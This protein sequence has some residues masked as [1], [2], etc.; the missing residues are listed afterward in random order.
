MRAEN[1]A[2]QLKSLLKQF[3]VV[4]LRAANCFSE[5]R[6]VCHDAELATFLAE[7]VF[8]LREVFPV[9]H[10]KATTA[11]NY[12][13][14]RL[15][16]MLLSKDGV[17]YLHRLSGNSGQVVLTFLKRKLHVL[18]TMVRDLVLGPELLH[19]VLLELLLEQLVIVHV[20]HQ[21][22]VGFFVSLVFKRVNHD[23]EADVFFCLFQGKETAHLCLVVLIAV[24][25]QPL[26]FIELSEVLLLR[27][28]L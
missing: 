12:Y 17:V 6:Y 4:H 14:S 23:F 22:E 24:I 3:T 7:C 13:V 27:L 1:A 26:A 21:S 8:V 5:A 11:V 9:A 16:C 28:K 15:H 20:L 19:L 2:V 10:F 25:R 18:L